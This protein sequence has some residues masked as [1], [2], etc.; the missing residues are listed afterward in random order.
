M[1]PVIVNLTLA[2]TNMQYQWRAVQQAPLALTFRSQ[3]KKFGDNFEINNSR[4]L[5]LNKTD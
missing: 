1:K 3:P 5:L 4:S 2:I